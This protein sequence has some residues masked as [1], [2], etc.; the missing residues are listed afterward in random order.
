MYDVRSIDYQGKPLFQ[1]AKMVSPAELNGTLENTA[2]FFYVLSGVSETVESNGSFVTAEKEGLLKSCGNFITRYKQG[3]NSCD[4]EAVVIFFYPEFVKEIYNNEIPAF[5][6]NDVVDNAPRKVVG[7]ELI[8]KFINGLFIYFDNTDLMDE[9]LSQLKMKELI[10]ILLKSNYFNGVVQFFREMFSP[11]NKTFR[12]VIENNI[13]SNITLDQLAFL[14]H[15]SLSGFKREF[16]KE[17]HQSP[18]RYIKN[19][20]LEEAAKMLLT[21]TDSISAI[22]FD[23]GF[24]DLST[25]SASFRDKFNS[26]PSRYRVTQISK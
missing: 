15:K 13:F 11:R 22:A 2:C 24:Q 23:C 19:R 18:A 26:S 20:K 6:S 10:M 12:E 4:F 7:N 8:E 25:F 16:Q 21:R 3:I 5:L 9:E 17:F 1:V 14:T